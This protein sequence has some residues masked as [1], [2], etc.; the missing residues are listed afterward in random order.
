MEKKTCHCTKA[1]QIL[2]KYAIDDMLGAELRVWDLMAKSQRI[3]D[4]MNDY[5]K[6]PLYVVF[7]FQG[8]EVGTLDEVMDACKQYGKVMFIFRLTHENKVVI[9]D[10]TIEILHSFYQ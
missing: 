4:Y 1:I 9:S 2:A 3:M 7:R 6:E 5:H 8:A 10:I